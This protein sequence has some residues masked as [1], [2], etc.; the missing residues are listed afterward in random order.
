[1]YSVAGGVL[2]FF[3][4]VGALLNLAMAISGPAPQDR[5]Q[6][7]HGGWAS[8]VLVFLAV[9]VLPPLASGIALLWSARNLR[10]KGKALAPSLLTPRSLDPV[11]QVEREIRQLLKLL[12]GPYREAAG[13]LVR[14]LD[15]LLRRHRE[16]ERRLSA[17]SVMANSLP[18]AELDGQQALLRERMGTERDA[19]ILASLQKQLRGI[20]GQIEA[21]ESVETSCAR[22]KAARDASLNTLLCLKAELLALSAS[23]SDRGRE[24]LEAETGDLR[25]LHA[26]L[27][28][29]RLATEEVLRISQG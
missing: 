24:A 10:R 9:F 1:V 4:G 7:A 6:Y 8:V 25:E 5:A 20:E 13:R 23:T 26:E 29:T 27:H 15:E 16:M 11:T 12:T 14:E 21:R 3:G 17:L 19:V 22:L 2:A 18:G 28:Q